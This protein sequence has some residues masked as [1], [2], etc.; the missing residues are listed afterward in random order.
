MYIKAANYINTLQ[1]NRY[2]NDDINKLQQKMEGFFNAITK[3]IGNEFCS[4]QE[5]I[6]NPQKL[7]A[8]IF[9][10]S[11]ADT[12]DNDTYQDITYGTKPQRE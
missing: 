11:E 1:K 3:V 5:A 6:D 10:L 2:T 9:K 8:H 7:F 4:L 12:I